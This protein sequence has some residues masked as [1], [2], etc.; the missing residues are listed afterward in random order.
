[1]SIFRLEIQ[2]GNKRLSPKMPSSIAMRNS[3]I[4]I[5][6]VI[7]VNGFS[8]YVRFNNIANDFLHSSGDDHRFASRSRADNILSVSTGKDNSSFLHEKNNERRPGSP[9]EPGKSTKKEKHKRCNFNGFVHQFKPDELEI[10]CD[11][12]A[13][14]ELKSLKG[15]GTRR[16]V[17][18]ATWHG[19]TIAVKKFLNTKASGKVSPEAAVL[20][21][22][23]KAEN[24]AKL[25]GWCNSTLI[26]EYAPHTL[27]DYQHQNIS[28]KQALSL[29]LDVVKGVTQLHSIAGGPVAHNDI[30]LRQFLVNT[31]GRVLLG[32]LDQMKFSGLGE[33]GKKCYYNTSCGRAPE[34]ILHDGTVNESSD[35]YEVA[36]VLWSLMTGEN[37]GKGRANKEVL[38]GARPSLSLLRKYPQ[39]LQHWCS[40]WLGK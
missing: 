22:L 25:V 34:K 4:G 6:L 35:I 15:N 32:D 3:F 40:T 29:G 37:W 5:F 10:T 8:Q 30:H 21:Q 20:F 19:K 7:V 33:S 13:E 16:E 17:Y 18:E 12:F 24:F 31:E 27:K 11:N 2:S 39:E 14:V 26:L 28:V 9:T 1:M 36:L 23:R 38:S